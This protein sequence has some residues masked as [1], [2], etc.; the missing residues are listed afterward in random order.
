MIGAAI[1]AVLAA[2]AVGGNFWLTRPVEGQACTALPRPEVVA[3]IR[4]MI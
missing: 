2:I 4:T 1:V 3:E